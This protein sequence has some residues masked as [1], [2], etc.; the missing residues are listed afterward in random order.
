MDRGMTIR[1]KCRS[2]KSSASSGSTNAHTRT[3]ARGEGIKPA[4]GSYVGGQPGYGQKADG[5]E[6]VLDAGEGDV[7][8]FVRTLRSQGRSYREICAALELVGIKPRR[9][10]RW[11]P[12]VAR[13]S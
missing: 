4:R 1:R 10:S 7:V 5:G 8:A 12:R 6:L 9:A 2:A 3:H 11:H 13:S